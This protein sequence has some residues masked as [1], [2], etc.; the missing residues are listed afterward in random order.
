M[1][2]VLKKKFVI[3]GGTLFDFQLTCRQYLRWNSLLGPLPGNE[4]RAK[5]LCSLGPL[6]VGSLPPSQYI[7][8]E[9]KCQKQYQWEFL[10]DEATQDKKRSEKQLSKLFYN[11]LL[12]EL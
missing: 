11:C 10:M 1:C 6:S 12:N 3:R 7:V 5:E 9:H 4:L 2:Y 8:V